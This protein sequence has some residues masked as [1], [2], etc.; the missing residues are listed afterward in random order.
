MSEI[1]KRPPIIS[2]ETRRAVERLRASLVGEVVSWDEL[3]ALTGLSKDRC[4]AAARTARQKLACEGVLFR[5][6]VGR[7]LE[8]IDDKTAV[9][10]LLPKHRRGIVGAAKRLARTTSGVKLDALN[11]EEKL[12]VAAH[13]TLAHFVKQAATERSVRKLGAEISRDGKAQPVTPAEATR[14]LFGR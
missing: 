9:S 8:R 6:A 2:I 14:Y 11:P 3:C 4:Y 1:S 13:E 12:S 7:G 5:G 10:E